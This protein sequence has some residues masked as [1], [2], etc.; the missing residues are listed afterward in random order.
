MVVSVASI[1]RSSSAVV[2]EPQV[3]SGQRGEKAEADVGRRRPVRD[4]QLRTDLHVVGRQVM[5]LG[6]DER[7][8]VAPRLPRDAAG[9]TPGP[10]PSAA[11]AGSS[12]GGSVRTRSTERRPTAP[13]PGGRPGSAAGRTSSTISSVATASSG[14]AAIP[15]RNARHCAG[16]LRAALAAAVSHSSRRRRVTTRRTRVIAIACSRSLASFAMKASCSPTAR[17]GGLQIVARRAQERAPRL[18]RARTTKN[19]EGA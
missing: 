9:D 2:D 10:R 4:G 14:L 19:L 7:V 5:V 15:R 13:A 17:P 6:A 8:E 3:V 12:W 16:P 18:A 11:P 1:R